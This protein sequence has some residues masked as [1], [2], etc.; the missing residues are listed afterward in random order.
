MTHKAL[1]LHE[2]GQNPILEETA[3]P[4]PKDGQLLIKVQG[5]TVNPSDR[6]SLTGSYKSG[7][8]PATMGLEGTG[9]VVEAK[10]ENLQNWVGKRVCFLQG[11]SGSWG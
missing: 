3:K 6:I 11:G 4:V 5:S 9:Q 2:Y 8:L 7:P 10:G 1:V